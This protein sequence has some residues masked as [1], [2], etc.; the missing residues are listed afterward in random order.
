LAALALFCLGILFSLGAATTSEVPGVP[1]GVPLSLA[2][3]GANVEHVDREANDPASN[4]PLGSYPFTPFE[5]IQETD[6]LPVKA[7]VLT[8]LVQALASFLGAASL[9]WVLITNARGRGA[10]VC[11]V[12]VDDR[13]WL[14][15]ASENPS[16]LGVFRL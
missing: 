9:S 3:E 10:L 4:L 16:F 1:P 2:L 5:E 15:V 11:S 6:K 8:W 7:S 14:A 13:G 12:V